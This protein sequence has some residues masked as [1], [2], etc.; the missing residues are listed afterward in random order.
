VDEAATV[1][2][3]L[4]LLRDPQDG[5]GQLDAE[6]V[7]L[8]NVQMMF[9]D[10]GTKRHGEIH[11][12]LQAA[13]TDSRRL[14]RLAAMSGLASHRD[15]QAIRLLVDSLTRPEN[16]LFAPADAIRTLTVSGL[17]EHVAVVRPYLDSPD[18]DVR[19]AAVTA[20][21]GDTASQPRIV[22]MIGDS[23]E[24]FEV[25]EAAIEALTRGVPGAAQAVTALLADP[26]IDF[27]LRDRASAAVEFRLS[28]P[29]LG[30]KERSIL[31]NKKEIQK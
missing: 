30:E 2:R 22:R 10:E 17:A 16:A 15:P 24:T 25:R 3:S 18:P 12:A 7:A 9:T 6:A 1:E 13:L 19:A 28:A 11:A 31:K 4:Q 14:V 21:L 8:L 23:S 27:R 26:A 20:L 29:D 5:G